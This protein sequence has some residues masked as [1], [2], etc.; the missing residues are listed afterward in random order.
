MTNTNNLRFPTRVDLPEGTRSQL[1]DRTNVV[2]GTL[3]D[4]NFQVKQAH[5]NIK[6]PQFF[7]RHELFDKLA[8][9]LRAWTDDVAE[10]AA[11]LGGYAGGTVR[12]SAETS[13]LDEYD[14]KA[15]DG[16]QHIAA[17]IE[18]YGR[19]TSL[20]RESVEA[21]QTLEDPVTEDLFTEVLRGTEL[22]LWF[23]ESH[24]NT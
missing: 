16:R 24:M 14:L 11:T 3:I 19:V 8:D 23:L 17:L 5:W 4:M 10:R 7:A 2:L 20:L 21:S 15:V 1:V 22:D 6:G 18:R 9:R 13:V 12:L